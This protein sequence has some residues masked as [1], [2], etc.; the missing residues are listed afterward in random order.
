M[1]YSENLSEHVAHLNLVFSKLQEYKLYVKKEECEFCRQEVKFLGHWVSKGQIRMDEKK[2]K[3]VLDWSP[4]T[5]VTYLRSFSGLAIYYRRFKKWV[6]EESEL[7]D[8]L[9]EAGSEMVLDQRVPR[10]INKLKSAVVSKLIL[11]LPN[12][13]L[14]FEV[15]TDASDHAIGG[16]LLQEGHSISVK[17]RKLKEAK[18]RDSI[19]E[20]EMAIDVHFGD[21]VH[22][23]D[24]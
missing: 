20:K 10:R 22:G 5:K 17:S 21:K 4:P 14:P 18:Q 7:F 1:F 13:E 2:V 15:Y 11:K 9:A 19:Y 24:E 16:F 8:G 3:Y 23:Y 6:I 12:F